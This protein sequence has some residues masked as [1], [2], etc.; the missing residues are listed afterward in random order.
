MKRKQVV[1]LF[2]LC[3]AVAA[4]TGCSGETGATGIGNVE[5]MASELA[6]TQPQKGLQDSLGSIPETY[7]KTIRNVSFNFTV[8]APENWKNSSVYQ[9]KAEK[10]TFNKEK[11][12]KAFGKTISY[13]N[14]SNGEEMPQ[15]EE[16]GC[17]LVDDDGIIYETKLGEHIRNSVDL[18]A[19]DGNL[20]KYQKDGE[21]SFMTKQEAYTKVLNAL[22]D[23]GIDVG[24]TTYTSY[25]LDYETMQSQEYVMDADG[26]QLEEYKKKDWSREDDCYLFVIRQK[27]QG[28]AEYHIY[29]EE[30]VRMEDGNAPIQVC[31]S[32]NGIE[33][34]ELEKIFKF[35]QEEGVLT[36]L[37]FEEIAQSAV[38]G[39]ENRNETSSY[40]V[41]SGQLCFMAPSVGSE[42]KPVWVLQSEETTM[43]G[44]SYPVT[45]V[46]DAQSGKVV[47]IGTR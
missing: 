37:D 22:K 7:T 14:G 40:H 18:D 33:S 16:E 42:M 34:M 44:S 3:A 1:V 21:L 38:K 12:E 25:A 10:I 29:G 32:K 26:S 11:L 24:D 45:V 47:A 6:D 31:Y 19:R 15:E 17:F 35:T 2:M 36:M 20:D 43:E 5:V 13:D 27:V 30:F 39:L 4:V 28:A 23:M 41:T 46:L 8:Q 9:T